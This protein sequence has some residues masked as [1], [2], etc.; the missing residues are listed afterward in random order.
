MTTT[1]RRRAA[2]TDRGGRGASGASAGTTTASRTATSTGTSTGLSTGPSVST[3][4]TEVAG[5][6]T[7]RWGGALGVVV[8]AVLAA[9]G[10]LVAAAGVGG[11]ADPVAIGDPGPVTRWGLLV[12]RTVYDV[13]AIGTLGVLV[14]AVVLLPRT[15]D[16]FGVDAARLVRRVTWWAVAWAVT[17][18]STML[19]T[20]SDVAGAAGRRRARARTSCPLVLDLETTR[21]LLSSAWLA[22]LVAVGSRVTR[23]P[24]TGAAAPAHRGRR[25]GAAAAHRARRSRRVPRAH[26]DEP[27]PARGRGRGVGRW[28]G[29]PGGPPPP[30]RSGPGGRPAPLQPHRPRL[31]RARR[32]VRPAHR[33]AVARRAERPVDVVLRSAAARQGRG[34]RGAGAH[35]VPAP[36]TH[37]GRRRRAPT[38]RLRR[39][40]PRP[41]SC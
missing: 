5:L 31:L 27:G 41:S 30:V 21:S 29:G 23:S 38:T 15:G 6:A 2:R 10:V 14:V 4:A 26:R 22:T 19:F 35:R 16:V 1:P 32:R 8:L 34:A 33:L 18:I 17:A 3:D 24:A 25:G 13:A 37:R 20:L 11:A 39:T 40:W 36:P 28:A 9:A 12:S 7:G